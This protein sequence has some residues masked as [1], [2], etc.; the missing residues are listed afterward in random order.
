MKKA[1]INKSMQRIDVMS[2]TK[3]QKEQLIA[4]LQHFLGLSEDSNKY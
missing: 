2:K 4:I 1:C 3:K